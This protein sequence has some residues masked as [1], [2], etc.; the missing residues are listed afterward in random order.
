MI[1]RALRLARDIDRGFDC[2][3]SLTRPQARAFKNFGYTFACRYLRRGELHPYDLSTAEVENILGEGLALVPVQHVESARSWVPSDEKGR[4]Y[5]AAAVEHARQL[6]LPSGSQLWCDLE[7]VAEDTDHASVISYCNEWHDAVCMA[8]F[9]AGLYVGWH[10]GLTPDELYSRLRFNAYWAA[11]NLNMDEWPS[12][13]GVQMRQ[14]VK[15]D[16][17]VPNGITFSF[18]V[19]TIRIDK[20]GGVPQFVT[21]KEG[22]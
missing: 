1:A 20:L 4:R 6:G 22:T 21:A 11:Y 10:C 18:D 19:N 15:K 17:D 2:N 5:G 12:K 13:R 7:G 8:G 16:R 3:F 14:W 9:Q